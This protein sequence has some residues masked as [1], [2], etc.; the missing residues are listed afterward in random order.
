MS[1]VSRTSFVGFL[2][3]ALAASA[4]DKV[5][6]LAPTNTTIRLVAGLAVLPVAGSTEITAVVIESAGT[7]VQ[8]GTVVTFTSSLGTIEPREARTQN[9]QVTVRFI[10]GS[11]SGSAKIG[12]FSGGAK[13]EDVEILVGAAAA[14]A[15]T[16]RADPAFV[17]STGAAVGI[18]AQVLDKGGNPL[19]GVA[20]TFSAEAGIL[21]QSTALTNAGGEATVE[22]GTNVTTRVT[23]T[24]GGSTTALTANITVTARDL[25]SL[26]IALAGGPAAEVG[27]P[28]V[29]SLTPSNTSGA[30]IRSARIDFNDGT[31]RDLGAVPAAITVPHTY[32][33]AGT[34]I[35][36]V[37]AT[38]AFGLTGTTTLAVIVTERSTVGVQVQVLSNL[39]GLVTFSAS[40]TGTVS[41][42]I[43]F[44]QWDFGDNT[45]DTTTGP[46]T[47][48]RYASTGI[49]V[50]RLRVVTTNG[51]EG[52]TTLTIRV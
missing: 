24:V 17:P 16:L 19:P 3:A 2:L 35:V 7:P 29:F 31:I 36:R 18:I 39:S 41:G 26:T 40:I 52:F 8:N 4:C 15:M 46:Q 50:V 34:Y 22:L 21:S 20:V 23:A 14:G 32:T 28:L 9:G 11:Q 48:H 6:L 45:G 12:A 10:A 51:Q 30:S 13:S 47:S 1:L 44:F 5:P 49:F 37:T 42:S 33:R 27:L 38:D 43:R 25:P